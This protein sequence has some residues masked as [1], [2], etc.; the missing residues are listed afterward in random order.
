[1]FPRTNP[2]PC[3]KNEDC[4]SALLYVSR[5]RTVLQLHTVH[6]IVRKEFIVVEW[7]DKDTTRDV[8]TRTT[9]YL[10]RR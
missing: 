9:N 8:G 4:D 10:R 6:V 1:M 3:P 5:C 7:S 2:G